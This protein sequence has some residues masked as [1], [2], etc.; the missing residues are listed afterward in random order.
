MTWN[1]YSFG[2]S[3]CAIGLRTFAICD[4][5][6]LFEDNIVDDS[7]TFSLFNNDISKNYLYLGLSTYKY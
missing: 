6:D 1:S 4:I 7:E 2:K 5:I 3:F